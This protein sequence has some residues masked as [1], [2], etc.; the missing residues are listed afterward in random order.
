MQLKKFH[1]Y[2]GKIKPSLYT[3]LKNI[4]ENAHF[5]ESPCSPQLEY[6]IQGTTLGSRANKI[7]QSK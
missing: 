2:F 7:R 6:H 3:E 5:D 1:E 4:F